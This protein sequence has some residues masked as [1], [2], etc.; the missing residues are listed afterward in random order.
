MR[1]VPYA[2]I[3]L[4]MTANNALAE[5][6]VSS[7]CGAERASLGSVFRGMVLGQATKATL[8][9]TEALGSDIELELEMNG[10]RVDGV[11]IT[12]SD[13]VR[14]P[15]LCPML[16]D[17]LAKAW[18]P[19]T[20][21]RWEARSRDRALEFTISN[22][23]SCTLH[24]YRIVPAN[25]WLNT[26]RRSVVPLWAIG[27]PSTQLERALAPLQPE[28]QDTEYSPPSLRWHDT[29]ISGEKIE[30]TAYY[31]R[32]RVIGIEVRLEV[33]PDL[34]AWRRINAVFGA[35]GPVDVG[36]GMQTWRWPR[37]P[38]IVLE[39]WVGDRLPPRPGQPRN[40]DMHPKKP[41]ETYTTILFGV[42]PS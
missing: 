22:P 34:Q 18:G 23:P 32:S 30:L 5:A 1:H 25:K 29:A 2:L 24:F 16:R 28:V 40:Q 3:V 14:E 4:V 8:P 10:T 31:A 38:G 19:P 7:C 17:K 35:P 41:D 13:T 39:N 15:P 26:S 20:G 12:I 27:K 33:D 36:D 11:V 6:D 37:A 9:P 42:T 21:D